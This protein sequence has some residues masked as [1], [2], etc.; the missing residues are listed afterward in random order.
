[1]TRWLTLVLAM[2]TGAFIFLHL[3]VRAII[4]ETHRYE[5]PKL[6]P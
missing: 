1:M 4:W 6:P 2:L 3:T 5:K